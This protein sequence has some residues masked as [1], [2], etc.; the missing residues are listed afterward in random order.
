MVKRQTYSPQHKIFRLLF[1]TLNLHNQC[2]LRGTAVNNEWK[3]NPHLSLSHNI[4]IY[5]QR[6]SSQANRVE[7]LSRGIFQGYR[8]KDRILLLFPEELC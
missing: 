8:M 1:P 7:T 3:T 5:P 4:D 2:K 6:I